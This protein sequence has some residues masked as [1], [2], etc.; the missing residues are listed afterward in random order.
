MEITTLK[1]SC[2]L[3]WQLYIG[4]QVKLEMATSMSSFHTIMAVI[5]H[6]FPKM[7]TW[8]LDQSKTSCIA[9]KNVIRKPQA[10]I[11]LLIA[12]YWMKQQSS[13]WSNGLVWQP[14][15][16][17]QLKISHH[18]SKKQLERSESVDIFWDVCVEISLKSSA[19][20]KRGNYKLKGCK[21]FNNNYYQKKIKAFDEEFFRP[22]RSLEIGNRFCV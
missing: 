9:L 13:T 4:C 10:I 20:H 19:G 11:W 12:L 17:T 5:L 22:Q 7:V 18:T 21:S 1:K 14:S 2:Q 15:R 3:F 16:N 8:C 6:L